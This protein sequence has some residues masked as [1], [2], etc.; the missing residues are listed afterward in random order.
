MKEFAGGDDA[1]LATRSKS[2]TV[3]SANSTLRPTTNPA[4]A[5]ETMIATTSRSADSPS[6]RARSLSRRTLLGS[7]LAA[8]LVAPTRRPPNAQCLLDL[9][10]ELGAADVR[11]VREGDRH[12]GQLPALFLRRSAGPRD[13][14]EEQSARRRAVRRPGRDVRRRHQ[15][16]HVRAVQAAVVRQAAGALQGRPTA[17]GPR[18]PTI[19]WS[20]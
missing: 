5:E 2:L 18:S 15:G 8:P 20:S 19:R 10:G 4:A 13:R 14:R 1:C 9:A 7:M 12:Q 11:G 16:R 17:S 3:R 6:S